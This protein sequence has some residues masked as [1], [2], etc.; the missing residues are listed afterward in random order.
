MEDL[1]GA[2]RAKWIDEPNPP[3]GAGAA[4]P[5]EAASD[6]SGSS[7]LFKAVQSMGLKLVPRKVMVEGL[8][9]DHIEKTPIEN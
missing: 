1:T 6:P 4:M 7:S 9:I 8:V 5:A 2:A 3:A